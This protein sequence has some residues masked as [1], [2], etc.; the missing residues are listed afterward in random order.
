MGLKL[1][2]QSI[3]LLGS[4]TAVSD[5]LEKKSGNNS[6]RMDIMFREYGNDLNIFFHPYVCSSPIETNQKKR[7]GTAHQAALA[8]VR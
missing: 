3:I 4:A 6:T 1:G 2:T 7:N 8:Q 5:L